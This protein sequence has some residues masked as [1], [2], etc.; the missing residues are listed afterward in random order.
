MSVSNVL[1]IVLI[2]V[3][4]AMALLAIPL[5]W[6]HSKLAPIL[7]V[8]IAIANSTF[9]LAVFTLRATHLTE[10]ASYTTISAFLI[11]VI[12]VERVLRL[13]QQRAARS[14]E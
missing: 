9:V 6:R 8:G 4:G 13:A 3:T 2:V 10:L 14:D 1:G 7:C 11:Q 12:I 5:C